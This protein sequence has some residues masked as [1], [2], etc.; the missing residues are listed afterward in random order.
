MMPPLAAEADGEALVAAFNAEELQIL[1]TDHAPHTEADKLVA[2]AGN[3]TGQ[4]DPDCNTCFGISGIEFVLPIM[5]SLVQRQQIKISRLFDALYDQPLTL[6]GLD[7][8]QT[9]ANSTKIRI[10]PYVIGEDDR[11]GR[12]KNH[13]YL[14]WTAWGR[15]EQVVIRDKVRYDRIRWKDPDWQPKILGADNQP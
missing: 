6:L 2:E 4:N 12:S 10:E 7:Y 11:V 15:I 9:A 3:P 5:I 1:E 8:H 14:G 13:P